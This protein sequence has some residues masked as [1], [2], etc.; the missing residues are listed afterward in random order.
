M[1]H[2]A[3]L[4]RLRNAPHCPKPASPAL[5]SAPHRPERRTRLGNAPRLHRVMTCVRLFSGV[6]C[7]YIVSLSRE[8]AMDMPAGAAGA[9]DFGAG[10]FDFS[11]FASD[12]LAHLREGIGAKAGEHRHTGPWDKPFGGPKGP[13]HWGGGFFGSKGGWWPGPPPPPPGPG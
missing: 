2:E 4:T 5:H 3:C 7:R 13:G 10:L 11:R 8:V 6:V 12:L 9:C 1:T